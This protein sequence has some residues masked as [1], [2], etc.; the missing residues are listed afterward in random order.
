MARTID[1]LYREIVGNNRH[2]TELEL[3]IDVDGKHPLMIISGDIFR[4]DRGWNHIV[5]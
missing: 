5:S 3:R 4:P 2:N 1:G